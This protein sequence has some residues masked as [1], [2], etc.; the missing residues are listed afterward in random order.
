MADQGM[1][2]RVKAR[3]LPGEALPEDAAIEEMARTVSDRV[4]IRLG[5]D[6]P[7][8]QAESIIVDATVK[9][10]RLRGFEGS[11]SE[12]LS[13]GGSFSNSFIDD[14]LDA[15]AEDLKWL[16]QRHGRAGV[17]LL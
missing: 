11:R 2:G 10:L 1:T 9:A 5:M 16:R 14:V 6:E 12:S 13:D 15:Y 4:A 3:Y 17:Q 7:P 8:K